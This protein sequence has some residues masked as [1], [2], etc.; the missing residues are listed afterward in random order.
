MKFGTTVWN[1]LFV[2]T[3]ETGT[4]VQDPN[5]RKAAI[6]VDD[7][8][9]AIVGDRLFCTQATEQKLIARIEEMQ[10]R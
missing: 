5:C 6:R 8:T 1:G 2:Q 10:A 4:I 7:N 3:V 9:V